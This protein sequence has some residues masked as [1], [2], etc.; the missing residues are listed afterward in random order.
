[1]AKFQSPLLGYNNN[2]RHRGRVF[3][4]QTEDS[5]VNHPHIITH[6]FMDGGRIL[7]SVKRSYAEHVGS[8]NMSET[9]RV[10]MKEQHKAMFIALRDGQYDELAFGVKKPSGA[11]A[12]PVAAP[13]S[14]TERSP[15]ETPTVAAPPPAPPSPPAAPS[16]PRRN[17]TP[18]VAAPPPPADPLAP[19]VTM[20]SPTVARRASE[21]IPPPAPSAPDVGV[22][23]VAAAP[24]VKVS[25]DHHRAAAPSPPTKAVAPPRVP[26]PEEAPATIDE[27]QRGLAPQLR[28]G[29]DPPLPPELEALLRDELP[30]PQAPAKRSTARDDGAPA[31]TREPERRRSAQEL[32]LDFDALERDAGPSPI[33]QH[34][35]LPPPPKNLF[36]K[37]PRTGTY[38]A[39]EAEAHHDAPR[40]PANRSQTPAAR[41]PQPPPARPSPPATRTPTQ[42][43]PSE[44]RYAPA[45]PA[46]IFGTASKPPASSS[47]IFSDDL[48][49]DKSLDEV[50]LSYLAEDLDPPRRK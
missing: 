44:G 32:T 34:S 28:P 45:R 42:K 21:V 24:V 50:I 33:F 30:P 37:E 8:E 39:V 6:L 43:P 12:A 15:H 36:T 49:S 35:D 29:A 20:P 18:T 41:T 13:A 25:S 10:L 14:A 23:V 31:T 38:S 5:G 40:P 2:V 19:T 48:V 17:E 9:V 1:M 7:K 47:S 27:Q 46:A 26:T 16:P 4:I 22:N 3:H 11:M